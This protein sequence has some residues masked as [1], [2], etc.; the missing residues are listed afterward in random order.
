MANISFGERLKQVRIRNA[1][2]QAELG[3]K[4]DVSQATI[5]QWEIGRS[6]PDKRQKDE[7]KK[8][9]G[10]WTS[11]KPTDEANE[12]MENAPGAL[13]AWLNKARNEKKMSVQE[14]A[15]AAGLSAP[16]IYNIENGRISNPQD[17]TIR[18]LEHALGGSLSAETKEEIRDEANIEGLGEFVEFDP[19]GS[20]LPSVQVSTCCTTL[21][22]GQ[23]M[24]G[25]DRTSETKSNPIKKRNGLFDLLS[26]PLHT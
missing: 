22:S 20:D 16:A 3:E 18:K 8:I 7:L 1:M 2:T 12:E 26:K 15:E 6:A 11:E 4:I 10:G 21:V 24:L 5:C 9:L 13:G 17:K 25:K 19:H 23:F 14:L